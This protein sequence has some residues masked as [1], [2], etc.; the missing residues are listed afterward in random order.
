M[1]ASFL[2]FFFT[3]ISTIAISQEP[4]Y[5]QDPLAP[6]YYRDY[7]PSTF[8]WGDR[9]YEKNMNG[10]ASLMHDIKSLEPNLYHNLQPQYNALLQ[11]NK[12][13]KAILWGGSGIGAALIV[14]S[15]APLFNSIGND[16]TPT[17]SIVTRKNNGP[18]VS[19]GLLGGGFLI[20][21]ITGVIYSKKIVRHQDILNFTNDFNYYSEGEKIELTMSPVLQFGSQSSAGLSISIVF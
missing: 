2:L 21:S 11:R 19:W 20:S 13:A 17:S 9:Y 5:P 4:R 18:K 8:S 14:A 6:Q 12:D 1:K 16:P 7:E 15:F 10:I 3:L